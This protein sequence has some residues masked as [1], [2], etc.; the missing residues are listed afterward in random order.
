MERDGDGD[1]F[2][3]RRGRS[4]RT[5]KAAAAAAAGAASARRLLADSRLLSGVGRRS[6][7][8]HGARGP[9]P[10][11]GRG[12]EDGVAGAAGGSGSGSGSGNRNSNE[13]GGDDD[14]DGGDRSGAE[15]E[16]CSG[17][18]GDGRAAA[19]LGCLGLLDAAPEPADDALF[20]I[21]ATAGEG[22]ARAAA[23]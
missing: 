18:N 19:L 8:A 6:E 4:Q 5:R 2:L 23:F 16:N 11:G 14:G 17:G 7:T 1:A 10:A 21:A 20:A 22:R 15:A 9:S 13:R 12:A 3:L